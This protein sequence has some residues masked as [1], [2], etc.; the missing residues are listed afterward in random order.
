MAVSVSPY[1]EYAGLSEGQRCHCYRGLG[2][3]RRLLRRGPASAAAAAAKGHRAGDDGGRGGRDAAAAAR[4]HD[5]A[6]DAEQAS[7]AHDA[8]HVHGAAFIGH[9]LAEGGGR[10]EDEGEPV[11]ADHVAADEHEHDRDDASKVE[12]EGDEA[13]CYVACA[14]DPRIM[15]G[16][17]GGWMGVW[18]LGR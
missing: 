7:T 11:G 10:R 9:Q 13:R 15:C 4:L 12:D 5:G 14:G 6:T 16:G 18:R 3:G 2:A 8:G 17:Q 1:T